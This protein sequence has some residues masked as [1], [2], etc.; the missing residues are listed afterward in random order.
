MRERESRD[1]RKSTLRTSSKE[2]AP[3]VVCQALP[4]FRPSRSLSSCF[5][6]FT[7]PPLHPAYFSSTYINLIGCQAGSVFILQRIISIS[8]VRLT[9]LTACFA[10]SNKLRSKLPVEGRSL[11]PSIVSEFRDQ[12]FLPYDRMNVLERGSNDTI[13]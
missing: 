4:A 9:V 1:S 5:T 12:Q 7:Q 2:E 6:I 13:I 3:F 8:Y 10:V 11:S